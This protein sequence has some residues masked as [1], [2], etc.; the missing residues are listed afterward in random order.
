MCT[1]TCVRHSGG[2]A[3]ISEVIGTR[4]INIQ[5]VLIMHIIYTCT[6]ILLEHS[7]AAEL[8]VP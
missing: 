8:H 2:L 6:C 3:N 4:K 7:T 5:A 1:Y